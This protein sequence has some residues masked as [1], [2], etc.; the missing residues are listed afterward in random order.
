MMLCVFWPGVSGKILGV[1]RTFDTQINIHRQMRP[2]TISYDLPFLPLRKAA[3][4]RGRSFL[5]WF[6]FF[7]RISVWTLSSIT[8]AVFKDG[9]PSGFP[10][11]RV[12]RTERTCVRAEY[13]LSPILASPRT[14]VTIH[15]ES[16][17]C[18]LVY[19][20]VHELAFQTARGHPI[21]WRGARTCLVT[22][23]LPG[24]S[25]AITGR[26]TFSRDVEA[27]S[28]ATVTCKASRR[29]ENSWHFRVM[30][31]VGWLAFWP[32]RIEEFIA[33]GSSLGR[34]RDESD[35]L[36]SWACSCHDRSFN[37]TTFP[38]P[39]L[40]L[41]KCPDPQCCD[42]E[43]D[44]GRTWSLPLFSHRKELESVISSCNRYTT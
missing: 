20:T 37:P 33:D 38:R 17:S 13:G 35:I 39:L 3:L 25:E 15:S 34:Y 26:P 14:A 31:Y 10:S 30:F 36:I 23:M 29:T 32:S 24:A 41:E 22:T 19:S 28:R 40:R 21:S 1:E 6:D 42:N 7:Q 43:I 2:I 27:T 4:E 16:L 5:T 8:K 18:S 11:R 12:P 9:Q 44:D